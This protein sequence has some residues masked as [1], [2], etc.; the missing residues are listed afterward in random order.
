MSLDFEILMN[1]FV[2]SRK[3]SYRQLEKV[4]HSDWMNF[5]RLY[6]KF[7]SFHN[8]MIYREVHLLQFSIRMVDSSVSLGPSVPL[9]LG[10]SVGW[11]VGWLVGLLVGSLV[12]L[13]VGLSVCLLVCLLFGLLTVC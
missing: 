9:S 5:M 6:I 4:K 8:I 3:L 13:L 7:L 1:M 10:L 12:G 11:S 2:L